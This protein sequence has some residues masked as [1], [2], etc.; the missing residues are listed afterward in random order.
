MKPIR[1]AEKITKRETESFKQYL[2]EI[3]EIKMFTTDEETA[4]ALKAEQGDKDAMDELVRRNLR[5]VVSIAKQYE[6]SNILLEDLINEGN[7]GLI[8]AA[9]QYKPNT[10]FKFITYAVSWIRKMI[11]EYIAKNGRIVRL[12]S[13]KING[14]SKLNQF[15]SQLEQ[16]F[17]RNVDISEVVTEFSDKLSEDEL[18][19]L[20]AISVLTFDSFDSSINDDDTTGTLYDV[21]VNEN[22]ESSDDIIMTEDLKLQVKNLLKVLKPRD[23]QIMV[24]LFGLDGGTPMSLKDVGEKV[25]LTREMVRQI[26]EKS[27]R[28]LREV[29][30]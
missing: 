21:V 10:G 28:K 25:G 26:R 12:P 3:S 2:N 1:I 11:M 4:C 18:N 20:A 14:L 23:R 9:Q 8:I 19:E 24:D 6:N 27:L 5:F 16:K 17:G 7:I 15:T 13:N 30:I 29:Y 22:A